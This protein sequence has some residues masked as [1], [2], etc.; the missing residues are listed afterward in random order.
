MNFEVFIYHAI[1]FPFSHHHLFLTERVGNMIFGR[2]VAIGHSRSLMSD[3]FL[4]LCSKLILVC[5][6]SNHVQNQSR[7]SAYPAE[8]LRIQPVK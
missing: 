6:H 4:S 3:I 5:M 8:E 1:S 7:G 2:F